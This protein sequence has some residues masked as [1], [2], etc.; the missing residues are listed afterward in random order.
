MFTDLL[1]TPIYS[2]LALHPGGYRPLFGL[3]GYFLAASPTFRYCA[4]T[5]CILRLSEG[6]MSLRCLVSTWDGRPIGCL[7]LTTNRRTVSDFSAHTAL[8]SVGEVTNL[9]PDEAHERETCRPL[10]GSLIMTK[11]YTASSLC[12]TA[13]RY[14]VEQKCNQCIYLETDTVVVF[15][16]S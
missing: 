6:Y 2:S 12:F 8:S 1:C 7:T 10:S 14:Y 16:F 11:N 4:S 9:G 3:L 5:Q 15:Y 13:D